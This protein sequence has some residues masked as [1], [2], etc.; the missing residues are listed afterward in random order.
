[1][2]VYQC[3]YEYIRGYEFTYESAHWF[4]IFK[5]NQMCALLLTF[6]TYIR[7]Y[8]Y[9]QERSCGGG[10]VGVRVM[11]PARAR[12]PKEWRNEYLK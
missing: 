5:I 10:G 4:R 6:L 7:I 8:F 2:R 3:V 11:R 9:W 12:E 1:M